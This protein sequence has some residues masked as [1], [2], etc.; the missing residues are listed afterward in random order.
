MSGELHY[1]DVL[2]QLRTVH[3]CIQSKESD[4]NER[5]VIFGDL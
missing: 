4:P 5:V 3:N 2:L 1:F